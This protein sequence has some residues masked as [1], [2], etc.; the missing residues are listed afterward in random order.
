MASAL[1]RWLCAALLACASWAAAAGDEFRHIHASE[2]FTTAGPTAKQRYEAEK[3]Y[4]QRRMEEEQ[5]K[6]KARFDEGK[7]RVEAA[8]QE[9]QQRRQQ[10]RLQQEQAAEQRRIKRLIAQGVQDPRAIQ[11]RQLE[12]QLAER[13]VPVDRRKEQA[14]ASW[15]TSKEVRD[16]LAEREKRRQGLFLDARGRAFLKHALKGHHVCRAE[17]FAHLGTT[18]PELMQKLQEFWRSNQGRASPDKFEPILGPTASKILPLPENFLGKNGIINQAI[19]PIVEK[20]CQQKLE[21][22]S[23]LGI[24]VYQ[25]GSE[26]QEHVDALERTVTVALPIMAAGTAI[27]WHLNLSPHPKHWRPMALGAGQL[28]MYEGSWLPHSRRVPLKAGILAMLF[29]EYRPV[30]QDGRQFEGVVRDYLRSRGFRPDD[31][32]ARRD[33]GYTITPVSSPPSAKQNQ[34]QR[35]GS[36]PAEQAHR[37]MDEL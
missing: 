25:S 7:A 33:V 14:D 9:Q 19:S 27:G 20:S 34:P 4:S 15:R 10:A 8:R 29:V 22:A 17:G 16:K 5:A 32:D 26:V 31:D 18:P 28:L 2:G 36:P 6:V 21:L 12:E 30:G 23:I 3:A 35:S 11:Q 37:H 1:N 24:R 13:P